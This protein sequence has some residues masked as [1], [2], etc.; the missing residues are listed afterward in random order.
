MWKG[1]NTQMP[2]LLRSPLSALH[3]WR[4]WI[5]RREQNLWFYTGIY[6]EI[7]GIRSPPALEESLAKIFLHSRGRVFYFSPRIVQDRFFW[8]SCS[9]SP[10]GRFLTDYTWKGRINFKVLTNLFL[11]WYWFLSKIFTAEF[12]TNKLLHAPVTADKTTE[13]NTILSQISGNIPF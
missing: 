3:F 9:Y 12:L 1:E 11:I 8:A 2:L 5:S 13:V 10:V 7:L 4:G 6:W